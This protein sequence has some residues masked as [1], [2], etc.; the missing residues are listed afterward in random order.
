MTTKRYCPYCG[1][2]AV[3]LETGETDYNSNT[4]L[5]CKG[6]GVCSVSNGTDSEEWLARS[7]EFYK[8]D[9]DFKDVFKE[10]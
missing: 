9:K 2:K 7:K 10:W 6:C 1:K 8:D 3:E 5:G 4:L